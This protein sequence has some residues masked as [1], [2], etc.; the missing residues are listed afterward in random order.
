QNLE[1]PLLLAFIS[2]LIGPKLL[3]QPF[4]LGIDGRPNRGILESN[5]DSIIPARLFRHVI[6]RRLDFHRKNA[7]ALNILLEQWIVVLQKELLELLLM[8][9]LHFVVILDRVR[10]VRGSMWWRALRKH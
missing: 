1:P 6:R 7:A 8:S 9:P 5:R 4:F 3:D 10:L 2:R